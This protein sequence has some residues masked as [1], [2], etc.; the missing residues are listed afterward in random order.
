[1]P[2]LN[3]DATHEQLHAFWRASGLNSEQIA[4][5][6]GLY[7]NGKSYPYVEDTSSYFWAAERSLGDVALSCSANYVSEK[8]HATQRVY[9]YYFTHVSKYASKHEDDVTHASELPYVLHFNSIF[10]LSRA[11]RAMA[12]VMA[13]YWGNF[14]ISEDGDP[15]EKHVGMG[16]LPE[17]PMYDAQAP[18]LLSMQLNEKDDVQPVQALK[19]AECGFWIPF[20]DAAI[21]ADFK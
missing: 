10:P 7:V 8:V 17:W 4:T 6:D 11:D 13:S 15:N 1:L 18:Q 16:D 19:E 20:L 14:L 12:D 21:R 3:R 2:D 9:H 5:L